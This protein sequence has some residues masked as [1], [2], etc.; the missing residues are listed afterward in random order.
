ME[1]DMDDI[2]FSESRL[3]Q[4][5]SGNQSAMYLVSLAWAKQRDGSVDGYATF[6]G[7]E[8]AESWDELRGAGARDVARMAGLNFA[9]SADS[10][11]VRLD[12][13]DDRAEAVIEGPDPEWL[14]GTGLTTEDSDRANELIFRQIAGNVGLHLEA[15]R[16]DEGLHLTFSKS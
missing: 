4:Q 7:D 1:V 14:E 13:D 8:F 10:K 15:R 6:V 16:D 11:F 5:A 12:G 9:S 3:L 2:E